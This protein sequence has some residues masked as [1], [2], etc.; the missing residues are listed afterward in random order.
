MESKSHYRSFQKIN[1]KELNTCNLIQKRDSHPKKQGAYYDVLSKVLHNRTQWQEN[2]SF[3]FFFSPV[4]E[5]NNTGPE[6]SLQKTKQLL[7]YFK[8]DL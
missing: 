1:I 4:S 5:T 2:C 6:F 3:F 7:R 8:K